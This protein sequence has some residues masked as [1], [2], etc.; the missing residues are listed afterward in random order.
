MRYCDVFK[1]KTLTKADHPWQKIHCA[2]Q[3]KAHG[4]SLFLIVLALFSKPLTMPN[5]GGVDFL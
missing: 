5:Q 4:E 3:S 1:I 2:R